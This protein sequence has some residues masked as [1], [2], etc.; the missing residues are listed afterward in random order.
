MTV[1]NDE[2][3]SL[4]PK[5]GRKWA[6]KRG[7]AL[8]RECAGRQ[9]DITTLAFRLLGGRDQAIEFLNQPDAHLGGRPLDIATADC[10]GYERVADLLKLR[11]NRQDEPA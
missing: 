3:T 2:G 4:T 1:T 6:P 11:A 5:N 8:S 7:P 10:A 9:G